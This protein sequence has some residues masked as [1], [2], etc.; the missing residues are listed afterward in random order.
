MPGSGSPVRRC[1]AC[2]LGVC[3]EPGSAEEAREDLVRRLGEGTAP[4]RAG[5]GAW[6]GG[7]GWAGIGPRSRYLHTP[8]SAARLGIAAGRPRFAFALMWQTLLNAFTFGHDV[9]LGRLGKAEAVPARRPWQ[10][11]LDAIVSVLAA[12]VV[13]AFAALLE[14][15]AW[16]AGRGGAF[17]SR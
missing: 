7:S 15:G 6:L 5:L 9:A 16:L 8:E 4:N 10:R 2:G 3:G 17:G 11:R 1:E 14:A 12:P 13:A